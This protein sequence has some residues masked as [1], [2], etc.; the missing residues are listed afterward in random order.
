MGEAGRGELVGAL[1]DAVTQ[2]SVRRKCSAAFLSVTETEPLLMSRL[3]ANG[4]R[5]AR[6]E[7]IYVLDLEWTS[8]EAYRQSLP[9]DN[10]RKNIPYERNKNRKVG[11]V[12]SEVSDPAGSA[13]RL[14][15]IVERHYQSYGWPA[16]PYTESWFRSL[17]VNLGSD[18][19]I[20]VAT[21]EGRVVAVTVSVRKQATWQ[22][23]LAGVDHDA[24]GNDFTHFNLSYYWPIDECMR[25]GDRRYVVGPGQHTA[26]IRR[27]YR[28]LNSYIYCRPAGPARRIVMRLWLP[29]LSAW[30]R[31]K[32]G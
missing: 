22:M 14:H 13:E 25:R 24:T 4:Y 5:R 29:V 28:P 17:K 8:F 19:V 2:E 3:S 31:R 9:S 11:V 21:R 12:I 6:H 30:L 20:A 18:A 32:A 16:F 15:A 23:V 1:V 27:G 10:I 26:R 7:P